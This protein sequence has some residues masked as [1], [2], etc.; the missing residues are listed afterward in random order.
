MSKVIWPYFLSRQYF[1][2][3]LNDFEVTYNKCSPYWDD[4]QSACYNHFGSKS[5]F[6]YYN[7]WQTAMGETYVCVTK[8]N[9]FSNLLLITIFFHKILNN[10]LYIIQY[11]VWKSFDLQ[12]LICKNYGLM[13]I[14]NWY[15]I[16]I[17]LFYFI[18][19][20]WSLSL[21]DIT[22]IRY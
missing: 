21:K 5:R 11:L 17:I 7:N 16:K 15:R 9:I 19:N 1:L 2:N 13:Y 14:K 6:Q 18:I 3:H 8:N 10:M 20:P 22:K 4:V 12:V